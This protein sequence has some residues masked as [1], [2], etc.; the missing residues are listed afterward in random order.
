MPA[1]GIASLAADT[2]PQLG[3]D[4]D[5]NSHDIK[6]KDSDLAIFGN[7]DDLK[8][9]HSSGTNYINSVNGNLILEQSNQEKAIVKGG[10]FSPGNENIDLGEA[11]LRWQNVHGKR[12]KGDG[13]LQARASFETNGTPSI[14][15]DYGVTSLG[16]NG[17][18]LTD[19]N[20]ETSYGNANYAVSANGQQD[21]GGGARFCTFRNPD[22]SHC[23]IE[24]RSH[25]NSALDALRIC[26]LFSGD[27]P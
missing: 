2:S 10:S 27:Q 3:G 5:T 9:F 13:V 11:S 24:F 17:T 20:F 21:S 16:D 7:G 1:A 15:D 14:Y 22:T 23:E 6:F 25:S 18:G 26:V 8:I 12:F 4:L 19:V